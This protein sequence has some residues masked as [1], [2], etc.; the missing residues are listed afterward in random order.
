MFV[1]VG[2][3]VTCARVGG[4]VS[5]ASTLNVELARPVNTPSVDVI[6]TLVPVLCNVV[7]NVVV[8]CPLVKETPVV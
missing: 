4:V 1:G 3:G 6:V 5:T 8:D 7:V 2:T